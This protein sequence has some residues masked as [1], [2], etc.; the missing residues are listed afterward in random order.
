MAAIVR[1]KDAQK[2]R[3]ADA[4]L[5]DIA[6]KLTSNLPP[7]AIPVF[8]RLCNSVDRTGTFKLIKT[9]LQRLGYSN[10]SDEMNLNGA[11]PDLIFMWDNSSK[12][13]VELN[14]G[15]KRALDSGE[16]AKLL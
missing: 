11:D 10:C 1:D 12:S 2:Y 3:S 13:Y 7:Y 15:K 16:M 4:F 14:E 8:I 5:V 6:E 9:N